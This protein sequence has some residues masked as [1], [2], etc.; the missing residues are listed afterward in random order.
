MNWN[1]PEDSAH[2]AWHQSHPQEAAEVSLYSKSLAMRPL[3]PC[4]SAIPAQFDV[5]AAAREVVGSNCNT[6]TLA[7][8]TIDS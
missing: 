7:N 5:S 1:Y 8:K 2:I 4:P 3:L 6:K